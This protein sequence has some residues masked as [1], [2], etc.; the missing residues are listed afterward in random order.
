MS[1]GIQL[2]QFLWLGS[3]AIFCI[4]WA[5]GTWIQN[6]K[7]E[8]FIWAIVIFSIG[9]WLLSGA[10]FFTSLYSFFPYFNFIHIPFVFLSSYLLYVYLKF[11]FLDE[12]INLSVYYMIPSL[13]SIFSLL[14][15]YR[16]PKEEMILTLSNLSN[17]TY[18]KILISLNLLIKLSMLFSVGLF[19]FKFWIPNVRIGIFF[20]KKSIYTSLFILL[21]W[22]DLMLG[23]I[24][25][26]FEYPL[27]RSLSAFF[28]PGL[29][30]FYYF[31]RPKWTSFVWDAKEDITRDKY[32]KSKL[33]HLNLIEIDKK[34]KQL[35]SEKVYCDE[36][37]TLEQLA[38]MCG[39]KKGQLSEFFFRK[40]QIGFYK[41]INQYR[42][43]EAKKQLTH[44]PSRSILSIADSVGFNSKSTF[45]RVFLEF[46]GKT[47]RDYR[48]H[49][50]IQN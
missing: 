20:Q 35:M 24:G 50:K 21:T 46:V 11:I 31:T 45:N 16:M 28:L 8:E 12:K 25:F 22:F 18:G 40:H 5:L 7:K 13:L 49:F 33:S 17:S 14:K 27:L 19:L 30:Y 36:D 4:V 3:G 23:T 2:L 15:F 9:L 38:E 47:P 32:E 39:L 44:N 48:E 42:I 26:I 41:Y 1:D 43:E 37:L 10:F 29:V 34:L 6:P